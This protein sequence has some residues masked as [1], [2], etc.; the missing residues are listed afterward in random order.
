MIQQR[1]DI[2]RKR[3]ANRQFLLFKTTPRKKPAISP[4]KQPG[5][6]SDLKAIYAD[7]QI[8]QDFIQ[9][10]LSEFDSTTRLTAMIIQIDS[11]VSQ[12][13]RVEDG[14]KVLAAA[15]TDLAA[16]IKIICQ[17]ENGHWGILDY[18]LFACIFGEKDGR[19]AEDI[20]RQVKRRLAGLRSDTLTI[21]IAEHPCLDY[22]KKQIFENAYKAL[23]HA[24][25]FGPDSL[26]ALDAV[27]L[28]ISGDQLY[29]KGDYHGAT[30]EFR[31]GLQL[32]P[33]NSNLNNSLGVTF[34]VLERYTDAL[35][36][37]EKALAIDSDEAMLLYNIGLV[38]L[39]GNDRRTAMD[40]FLRARQID[41]NIYELVFQLG[42]VHLEDGQFE[43][44]RVHLERAV[45]LNAGS[46]LAHSALGE[47]YLA[48]KE[49][50]RAVKAFKK[51]IQLNG[52]D[53][54]ALSGL[55]WLYHQGG[56][57]P[58]IAELFCR[59]SVTIA[60]DTG[61]YRHRLGCLLQDTGR[62]DEASQQLNRAIELGTESIQ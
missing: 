1:S 21:G 45:T 11:P 24:R 17:N 50:S 35:A 44:A 23:E 37:F 29:D 61:L 30:E 39:I 58:E 53:A 2:E 28:N 26:V 16:A 41:G 5:L 46:F 22:K 48:L 8:G 62:A 54:A 20:A 12:L 7:L 10:S 9:N 43:Q 47:C 13:D 14:L 27:S 3:S 32:D 19:S 18:P 55:G 34:G 51:A 33:I 40:Y 31:R 36:V 56:E 60:P 25:F 38:H 49:P 42:R 4:Q 59:Q 15:R 52:N 6:D 57:N